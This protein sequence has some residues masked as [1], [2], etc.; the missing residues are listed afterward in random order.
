MVDLP[1]HTLR[2]RP[3]RVTRALSSSPQH[4][5]DARVLFFLVGFVE[6]KLKR[7]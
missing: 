1:S 7:L 4:R 6:L 3:Q 5:G 2:V